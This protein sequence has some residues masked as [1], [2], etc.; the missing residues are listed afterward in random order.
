LGATCLA[1]GSSAGRPG[2]AASAERFITC[3]QAGF[4]VS[5]QLGVPAEPGPS[6]LGL[7]FRDALGTTP[8]I[9]AYDGETPAPADPDLSSAGSDV[10]TIRVGGSETVDMD[11]ERQRFPRGRQEGTGARGTREAHWHNSEV[12]DNGEIGLSPVQS[13]GEWSTPRRSASSEVPSS[14]GD[15]IVLMG[16]GR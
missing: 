4:P 14:P 3:S 15:P 11:R 5:P 10:R 1:R 2:G 8:W 7:S 9:G 16:R 6:R 13:G 12:E